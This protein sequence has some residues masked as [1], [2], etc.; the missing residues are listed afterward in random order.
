MF[1]LSTLVSSVAS[2]NSTSYNTKGL[3]LLQNLY[4]FK[5]VSESHLVS[6]HLVNS[7]KVKVTQLRP[8]LCNPMD[9]GP[10]ASSVHG[11]L[12]AKILEWVAIPFSEGFSRPRDQAQISHIAG[13][14]FTN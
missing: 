14:F 3:I 11:I 9:R 6:P 7:L 5:Q 10:P 2:L 8:A 4:I 13:R 12:Q 1:T